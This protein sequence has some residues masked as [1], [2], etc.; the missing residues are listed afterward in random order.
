MSSKVI[1]IDSGIDLKNNFFK[2]KVLNGVAIEKNASNMIKITDNYQDLNGH[3]SSCASVILSICNDVK[4]FPINIV[5]KNK[6]SSSELLI[7]ALKYC[8]KI[9]IR[10][11]CI[12]MAT[13]N[14]N[15]YKE[16]E[17]Q[18]ELLKSQGKIIVS[19]LHNNYD[20]SAP[21]IFKSV[22]GVNGDDFLGNNQIFKYNSN[23]I[24]QGTF[25]FTPQLSLGCNGNYRF[26][27]GTS[28]ANAVASG[29]ILNILSEDCNITIEKLN[30]KLKENAIKDFIK[31]KESYFSD[32]YDI[33]EEKMIIRLQKIL[34]YSVK[35]NVDLDK[36]KKYPLM[37][38]EIGLNYKNFFDFLINISEEYGVTFN[39]KSIM[40]Y[41]ICTIKR[42]MNYILL[43]IN[44]Q[45]NNSQVSV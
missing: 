11:I 31:P 37:T 34:E 32:N 19:S 42:L 5:G 38:K 17:K 8:E 25:D 30:E 29:I 2:E 24:I 20:R 14:S 4:I 22:I 6:V 26:F 41:D 23:A 28:K 1:I 10:T 27:K 16:I 43:N 35:K 33:N 39:Y 44:R 36:L 12:S 18:C 3:G 15:F 7:E 13:I 45:A 21:A 9:N 40:A